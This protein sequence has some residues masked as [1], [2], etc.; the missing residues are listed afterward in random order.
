VSP[1]DNLAGRAE[2]DAPAKEPDMIGRTARILVLTALFATTM[3]VLATPV[4][5][6]PVVASPPSSQP[7][8][9]T[10]LTTI[11]PPDTV[12]PFTSTGGVI[13]AQGEV[14]TLS[15]VFAGGQSG[16][17]AQITTVK[18]FVCENGTFDVLLRV[19]L[20]FNTSGTEGTW[21]VRSG[22]GSFAGL[23][24]SG[25]LTGTRVDDEHVLDEFTGSMPIN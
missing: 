3:L 5:A 18:H 7:V 22:T 13:C 12:D 2:G 14:S 24:G 25:T 6:T 11:E 1:F 20:D 23:H 19:T 8:T 21:T 16:T 10:V 4:V 17:H 15:T 9:M